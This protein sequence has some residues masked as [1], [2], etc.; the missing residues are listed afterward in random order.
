MTVHFGLRFV[1]TRELLVAGRKN[2]VVL[3]EA[4]ARIP[5]L[6]RMVLL[7]D[8]VCMCAPH[9]PCCMTRLPT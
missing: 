1:Q 3:R 4:R 7:L 5:E 8:K 2:P 9:G 6:K